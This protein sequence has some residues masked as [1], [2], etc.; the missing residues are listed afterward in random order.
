ASLNTRPN[1]ELPRNGEA[2][3]TT[4]GTATRTEEAQTVYHALRHRVHDA[5]RHHRAPG[6]GLEPTTNGLTVR[7]AADCATPAWTRQSTN[8]PRH[9]SRKDGPMFHRMW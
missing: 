6:V 7:C 2:S 8:G 5:P 1:E 9:P 4:E 3:G